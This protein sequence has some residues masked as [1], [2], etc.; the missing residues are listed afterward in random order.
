MNDDEDLLPL[1]PKVTYPPDL[2]ASTSGF[3]DLLQHKE[4]VYCYGSQH[5]G[6]RALLL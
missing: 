4:H 3:V 1:P 5:A 2:S 6:Q